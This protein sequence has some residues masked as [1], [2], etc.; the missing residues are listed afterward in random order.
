[1][2]KPQGRPC[3]L[4][5]RI[6]RAPS[7]WPLPVF[8]CSCSRWPRP[9]PTRLSATIGEH[10]SAET[11][12]RW[13]LPATTS[14][15]GASEPVQSGNSLTEKQSLPNPSPLSRPNPQLEPPGRS[16]LLTQL[17]RHPP[18]RPQR[19][20]QLPPRLLISSP[21][22]QEIQQF[23]LLCSDLRGAGWPVIEHI[24]GVPP[25]VFIEELCEMNYLSAVVNNRASVFIGGVQWHCRRLA[26]ED[27]HS[28]RHA[29]HAPHLC[30]VVVKPASIYLPGLPL[31]AHWSRMWMESSPRWKAS[32]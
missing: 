2:P 18:D 5:R 28:H 30:A 26:V 14:E 1:M 13:H 22:H 31:V 23:D 19:H 8:P 21:L 6:Q 10:F 27:D 24:L 20:P 9:P 12:T 16:G 17:R 7:R 11:T 15:A 29:G 32:A 3:R 4:V 25:T